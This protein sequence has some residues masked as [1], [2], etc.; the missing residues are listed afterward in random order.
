MN[1]IILRKPL[2]PRPQEPEPLKPS[3]RE[4]AEPK[5]HLQPRPLM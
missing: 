3:K 2:F 1:E 4:P 5:G